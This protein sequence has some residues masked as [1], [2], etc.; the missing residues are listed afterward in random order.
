MHAKR[1]YTSQVR[2]CLLWIYTATCIFGFWQF[3][4]IPGASPGDSPATLL[5]TTSGGFSTPL[6]MASKVTIPLEESLQ[7]LEQ[8]R[9]ITSEST[10]VKSLIKIRLQPSAPAGTIGQILELTRE[11]F[12]QFPGHVSMPSLSRAV[13]VLDETQIILWTEDN[14]RPIWVFQRGVSDSL[15]RIQGTQ[16][17]RTTEMALDSFPSQ[18]IPHGRNG[19][20][21]KL[22]SGANESAP[23]QFHE[24]HLINPVISKRFPELK[25]PKHSFTN[26]FESLPISLTPA[27]DKNPYWWRFKLENTLKKWRQNGV[28]YAFLK[29]PHSISVNTWFWYIAIFLLLIFLA[30]AYGNLTKRQL[31]IILLFPGFMMALVTLLNLPLDQSNSELFL[32]IWLLLF[33]K[34]HYSQSLSPKEILLPGVIVLAIWFCS[35]LSLM[36]PDLRQF[37]Q[38]LLTGLIGLFVA[39]LLSYA[40]SAMYSMRVRHFPVVTTVLLLG[41]SL[42]GF[43]EYSGI[44]TRNIHRLI[45]GE[46]TIPAKQTFQ[47]FQE[48]KIH[49]TP[50][51]FAPEMTEDACDT[52]STVISLFNP[53]LLAHHT[54][55]SSH[56]LTARWRAHRPDPLAIRSLIRPLLFF[57]DG[58]RWFVEGAGEPFQNNMLFLP[59]RFRID[60]G[61]PEYKDLR[62][63]V[64]R[65]GDSLRTMPGIGEVKINKHLNSGSDYYKI[66]YDYPLLSASQKAQIML[67]AFRY[68]NIPDTMHWQHQPFFQENGIPVM[69]LAGLE[70]FESSA[71][72]IRENS[73]FII[74]VEYEHHGG[75]KYAMKFYNDILDSL[76]T[77]LPAS[78]SAMVPVSYQKT[79]FPWVLLPALL[80]II[81][82][83]TFIISFSTAFRLLDALV[84]GLVAVLFYY[85]LNEIALSDFLIKELAIEIIFL[86]CLSGIRHDKRLWLLAAWIILP[87][88]LNPGNEIHWVIRS[89]LALGGI[90][91]IPGIG[92]FKKLISGGRQCFE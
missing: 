32:S 38:L 15:A 66:R 43:S 59:G 1:T 14:S 83:F 25:I 2:K 39:D 58:I 36:S 3:P 85:Y 61:G 29:D 50:A 19:F 23:F 28:R 21:H 51:T 16:N 13:T 4:E 84:L 63:I 89:L 67:S 52:L 8:V 10:S 90:I 77:D 68:R 48:L 54:E 27:E 73:R 65:F 53:S 5:I 18:L 11:R 31:L 80:L 75:E 41:T 6:E 71:P 64:V 35:T 76:N 44:T 45:T 46:K 30:F 69:E 72:V 49:G 88:T 7:R 62:K 74:P 22:S 12:Q 26:G 24:G 78:V 40:P 86:V 87:Y 91:Y 60:L 20:L 81:L 33:M 9:D 37:L 70:R 42:L 79:V 17:L 92:K 56:T 34:V 82:L 55:G 57:H 47:D